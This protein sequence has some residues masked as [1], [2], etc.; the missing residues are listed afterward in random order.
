MSQD[1]AILPHGR[2]PRQGKEPGAGTHLTGEVSITPQMMLK[3][4]I[5]SRNPLR[6]EICVGKGNPL[7]G[8][9]QAP[10][11]SSPSPAAKAERPPPFPVS[12]RLEHLHFGA[13]LQIETF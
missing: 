2:A 4:D 9:K 11:V 12:W 7:V 1:L 5:I 3:L 6:E 13:R 10:P 8:P